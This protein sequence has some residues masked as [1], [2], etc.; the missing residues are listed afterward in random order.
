MNEY[1][2]HGVQ[3]RVEPMVCLSSGWEII[4]DQYWMFFAISLAGVLLASFVPVGILLGPMYCGIFYAWFKLEQGEKLTFEMLFKGFDHF[5]ESLIATL[6]LIGVGMVVFIPTYFILMATVILGIVGAEG[7]QDATISA[8]LVISIVLILVIVVALMT[9][10]G[11]LSLFI[12]PLIVD[13][14]LKAIPAVKAS[15]SAG[16]AHFG[17]LFALG[18]LLS[19]ISIIAMFFCY[20]PIFLVMPLFFSTTAVVYRKVFPV[21]AVEV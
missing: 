8:I 17:G 13:R 2:S 1:S 19:I 10:A 5:V 21:E 18:I 20:I 6:I 12:Y 14:N 11:V 15:I 3:V 9:L 4:K 16:W 7:Q